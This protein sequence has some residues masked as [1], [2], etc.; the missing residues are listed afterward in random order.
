MQP[1]QVVFPYTNKAD[2]EW[3]AH[4]FRSGYSGN[5]LMREDCLNISKKTGCTLPRWLMKDPTRRITRG[6][7]ACPELELYAKSQTAKNTA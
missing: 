2:D 3:L 6:C 7:Y 5:S 1:N 4:A